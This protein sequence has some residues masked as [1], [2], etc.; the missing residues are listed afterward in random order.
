MKTPL[1][2]LISAVLIP[3]T[4][5]A[6]HPTASKGGTYTPT[7]NPTYQTTP[8]TYQSSPATQQVNYSPPQVSK[9]SGSPATVTQNTGATATISAPSHKVIQAK[10]H[11]SAHGRVARFDPSAIS[12]DPVVTDLRTD[13]VGISDVRLDQPNAIPV[14][15]KTETTDS[16]LVI[17]QQLKPVRFYKHNLRTAKFNDLGGYGIQLGYYENLAECRK[18]L[19]NY[20]SRFKVAGFICED[21]NITDK[22]FRLILGHYTHKS[23]AIR[24]LDKL[25]PYFPLCF[26]VK[27]A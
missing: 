3:F 4:G 12:L 22:R 16:V 27:Y 13:Q 25:R 20:K 19:A 10:S 7:S 5:F 17:A 6:Q 1:L 21:W 14:L 9:T 15:T 11:Y 18:E 26:I 8:A 24:L 2:F 23:T